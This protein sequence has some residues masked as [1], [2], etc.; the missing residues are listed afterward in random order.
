MKN[1]HHHATAVLR[2]TNFGLQE[3]PL[4][5][6]P[7]DFAWSDKTALQ[8][9]V[10]LFLNER[11]PFL[12]ERV[13]ENSPTISAFPKVGSG[14]VLVIDPSGRLR[15]ISKPMAATSMICGFQAT[16]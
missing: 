7:S 1:G 11:R 3:M 8:E 10:A 14:Q 15:P 13:P 16:I 2:K 5:G 9:L 12:L 6:E 4:M